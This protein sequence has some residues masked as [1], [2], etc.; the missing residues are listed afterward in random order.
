ML[1]R[2][3]ADVYGLDHVAA[4]RPPPR[5]VRHQPLDKTVVSQVQT[6]IRVR[7][8]GGGSFLTATFQRDVLLRPPEKGGP[9]DEE[10]PDEQ[11]ALKMLLVGVTSESFDPRKTVVF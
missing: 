10:Q 9:L 11:T 5:N 4:P 2:R 3:D 1:V 8:P 6:S 7:E